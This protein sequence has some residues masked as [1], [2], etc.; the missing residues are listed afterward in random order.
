VPNAVEELPR[1]DGPVHPATTRVAT[2]PM[3][4]GDVEIPADDLVMISL[5]S[6]NRDGERFEDPDRLDGTRAVGGHV[7]FG[8]GILD[9]VGAPLARWEA[10]IALGRMLVRFP[11]LA[12]DVVGWNRTSLPRGLRALPVKVG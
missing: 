12:L 6:A 3:L 2:E 1:F 8:Y 7:T 4:V 5:L 10:E 11:D 9:C